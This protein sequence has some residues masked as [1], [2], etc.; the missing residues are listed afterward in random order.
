MFSRANSLTHV[1]LRCQRHI[2]RQTSQWRGPET[3]GSTRLR[4]QSTAA[5]PVDVDDDDESHERSQTVNSSEPTLSITSPKKG[6]TI[7]TWRPAQSADLG[8]K[9]LGKPSEILILQQQERQYPVV[10]TQDE[11]EKK[12]SLHDSIT[13]ERQP[14]SWEQIKANLDQARE[15]LGQQRG[16]LTVEQWEYLR[17][18]LRN[19]FTR[20]QLRRYVNETWS[21]TSN[22]SA[23]IRLVKQDRAQLVQLIATKSWLYELPEGVPSLLADPEKK[24]SEAAAKPTTVSWR[25]RKLV[26]PSLQLNLRTMSQKHGVQ[27]RLEDANVSIQGKKSK[28][29]AASKALQAY[30]KSLKCSI[31]GAEPWLG[32]FRRVLPTELI[33]EFVESLRSKHRLHIEVEDMSSKGPQKNPTRK[34]RFKVWH[35]RDDQD[36]LAQVRHAL[37]KAIL[38]SYQTGQSWVTLSDSGVTKDVNIIKL[39]CH[40]KPVSPMNAFSHYCRLHFSQNAPERR[41]AKQSVVQSANQVC[42]AIKDAF[43]VDDGPAAGE[44]P[45]LKLRAEYTATFGQALYSSRPEE[46]LTSTKHRKEAQGSP[47]FASEPV[48]VPQLLSHPKFR[49]SSSSSLPANAAQ[50]P[51]LL[52]RTRMSPNNPLS[53]SPILEVLLHG[54]N[55]PA[56]LSQP[57]AVSQIT[58]VVEEKTVLVPRPNRAMD[59]KFSQLTKHDLFNLDSSTELQHSAMLKALSEYVGDAKIRPGPFTSLPILHGLDRLEKSKTPD[60]LAKDGV[61]SQD[62]SVEYALDSMEILD[63]DTRLTPSVQGS[64]NRY[65]LDHTTSQGGHF[66]QDSQELALRYDPSRPGPWSG[67]VDLGHFF[68]TTIDVADRIDALGRQLRHRM[69]GHR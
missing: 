23:G 18:T 31:I 58:A 5:A 33:H 59:I 6:Y 10:P 69:E 8:M 41:S 32:H 37:R 28:T 48:L 56:G 30:A 42:D 55:P 26:L 47:I 44:E 4:F 43:V 13:S 7:R 39:P 16:Q 20:T 27:L 12:E 46:G 22:E 24:A 61:E 36:S 52:V 57:F 2:T 51:K 21:R 66:G 63:I 29:V 64:T 68:K 65:L 1:C 54:S 50:K 9:A 67:Q 60:S 17:T 15:Q 45:A 38:P 19:G 40:T 62:S 34:I 3:R 49:E 35:A 53:K 11:Q 14:L 25:V